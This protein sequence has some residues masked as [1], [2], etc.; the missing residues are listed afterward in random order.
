MTLFQQ[1]MFFTQH[2]AFR[3]MLPLIRVVIRTLQYTDTI[4]DIL[5]R[6][7]AV[8]PEPEPLPKSLAFWVFCRRN[9]NPVLNLW[10]FT[11]QIKLNHLCR[12][13]IQGDPSHIARWD[14][15]LALLLVS[16]ML[17]V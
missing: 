17:L 10:V 8:Q 7:H 14:H 11:A 1:V 9:Y 2:L 4:G 6:C 12:V 13:R 16:R 15:T 3:Y 5:L